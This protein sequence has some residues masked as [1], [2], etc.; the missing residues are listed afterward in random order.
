MT[1]RQKRDDTKIQHISDLPKEV[2][3][4]YRKDATLGYVLDKER[5]VSKNQLKKK[6]SGN[7]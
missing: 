3:D 6:Y 2:T 1:F 7:C 4:K 5:S